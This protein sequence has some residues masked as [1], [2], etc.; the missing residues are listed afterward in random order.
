MAITTHRPSKDHE[1][2]RKPSSCSA[3]EHCHPDP[4]IPVPSLAELFYPAFLMMSFIFP[5]QL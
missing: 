1:T 5:R 3:I 2:I 4:A